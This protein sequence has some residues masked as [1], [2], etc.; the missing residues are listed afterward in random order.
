MN[1]IGIILT[2]DTRSKAYITKIIKNKIKIDEIIFMNDER[3]D[4]KFHKNAINEGKKYG[5]D[6]SKSIESII[7]ENNL[8]VKKF[9]FVDINNLKLM[10][11]DIFESLMLSQ[12]AL[13]QIHHIGFFS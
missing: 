5:F 7:N 11:L 6:I 13:I 10:K 4:K 2:P 12:N 1:K 9:N 8:L 3:E